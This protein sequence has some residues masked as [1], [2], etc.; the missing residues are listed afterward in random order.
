MLIM[1]ACRENDMKEIAAISDD[2]ELPIVSMR[3]AEI[4]FNDSAR[5]KAV[6][7]AGKVDNYIEYNDNDKPEEQR[8]VMSDGIEAEFYNELGEVNSRLTAQRATRLEGQRKTEIE[9]NVVVVN[10]NGDSLS[11]EYLLWNENDNTISS[12][13]KV[14]I[15]TKDEIIFADGF[16]SDVQ[17]RE[18]SFTN[19]T[20]RIKL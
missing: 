2:K 15:K 14:R 5:L 7:Q 3:N 8:L 16:E 13:K 10:V 1:A 20:G 18:Y 19:V 6:I 4:E 9:N 12:N 17:F 11:T